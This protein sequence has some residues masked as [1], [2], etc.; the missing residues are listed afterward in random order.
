MYCGATIWQL[1]YAL[2]LQAR[3]L[4]NYS[5]ITKQTTTNKTFFISKSFSES[6]SLPTLGNMKKPFH[7][8][9][10]LYQMRQSHSLLCEAK[11]CDWSRKITPLSNLTRASLLVEWNLQQRKNWTQNLQILK[12]MLDKSSQLLSSEQPS[13]P[14]KLGCC[15]AYCR[16]WEIGW[17]KLRLLSTWSP[18]DSSFEQKGALVTV[19]I[20]VLCGLWFSNQFQI[21]SETPFSCDTVGCKLYFACCCTWNR[22]EHL[23]QKVVRLHVCVYFHWF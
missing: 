11:N 12:K 14:K 4:F 16:S 18:F 13:G 20:C 5:I 22:L 15:L 2:E 1:D 8:I 3:A 7:V 9:Y 17:E 19:L 10:D 23:H 21:V 6:H